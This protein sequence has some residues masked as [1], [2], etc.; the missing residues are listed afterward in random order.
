MVVDNY[1][2]LAYSYL[3]VFIETSVFTRLLTSL[4]EDDQYRALQNTL[5]QNPEAGDLI[6]AGGGIRKVR[7]ALSGRGKSGGVWGIY[8]SHVPGEKFYMLTLYPKSAKDNL[9]AG[10]TAV[11]RELVN[12]LNL[13]G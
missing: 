1:P 13:Y 11:L 8:Y 4:M 12:E 7:H 10:E 9:T 2:P 6:P 3:M 5:L